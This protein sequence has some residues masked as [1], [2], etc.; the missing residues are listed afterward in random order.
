MTEGFDDKTAIGKRLRRL[1][2][3]IDQDAK[4]L[5]EAAGIDF[6][7]RWFGVL[8]LLIRNKAM[9]VKSLAEQL[10]ISHA[11]VSETRKSLEKAEIVRAQPDKSDGRARLLSLTPKGRK[12]VERLTPVWSALEDVSVELNDEARNVVA[13]LDRLDKALERQSLFERALD[14]LEKPR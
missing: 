4:R 10:R 13:A 12:L 3:V 9:T 11:S 5:Y 14:K 1:S 7:Q 6:E 2:N 8:N